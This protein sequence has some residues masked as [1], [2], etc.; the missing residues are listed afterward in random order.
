[1]CVGLAQAEDVAMPGTP[2]LGPAALPHVFFQTLFAR[3]FTLLFV[4]V[5]AIAAATALGA[6]PARAQA[7]AACASATD[8]LGS[9]PSA[10]V[11]AAV[12][13][14]VNVARSAARLGPVHTAAALEL[15]AQR[16]A[17]DMI[18]RGYFAHVS[19]SGGTVDKRARRAGYLTGP[20]WA[21]G[22]DLGWAPSAVASAQAVVAAWM[23]SPRH[24]SV[25]LDPDFR[26]I[27]IGLL[28]KAPTADGVG[29]TFV[30]ELG[31]AGPC[32]AAGS[33][34]TVRATPRARIRVS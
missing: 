12:V 27:G 22:E 16:H 32:A 11:E 29:A 2:P 23:E 30:L 31:A 33:T 24:R 15:S 18:A 10:T 9:A 13:C 4:L 19:P 6:S 20:C 26:D 8:P 7:P 1:L 14:L 3:R 25:I 28:T 5:A 34:G 21:L 17:A